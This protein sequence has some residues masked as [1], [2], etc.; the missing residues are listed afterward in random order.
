MHFK[1]QGKKLV[2]LRTK[3]CAVAKRGM[4]QT[5]GRISHD[6]DGI[7]A[8]I[9]ECLT[10]SEVIQLEGY[11]GKWKLDLDKRDDLEAL[12]QLSGNIK[13][14][15]NALDCPEAL[16]ELAPDEIQDIEN[17]IECLRVALGKV[18]VHKLFA[19]MERL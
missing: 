17:G 4:T 15:I 7:P 19:V 1:E 16:E 18:R 13:K 3:Y 5:V 8:D 14:S 12:R 6:M 2:L 9:L 11:F 10:S